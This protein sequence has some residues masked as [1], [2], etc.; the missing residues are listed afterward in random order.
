MFNA[1]GNAKANANQEATVKVGRI[2]PIFFSG[3]RS[4]LVLD[5]EAALDSSLGSSF[6]CSAYIDN[7]GA[8]Q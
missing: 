8:F 5:L 7:N 6:G 4:H 3:A 1:G 2:E